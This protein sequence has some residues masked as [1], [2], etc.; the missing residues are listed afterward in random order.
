MPRTIPPRMAKPIDRNF[1]LIIPPIYLGYGVDEMVR[2]EVSFPSLSK[3]R[4][5][6]GSF[7][8]DRNDGPNS[9]SDGNTLHHL[10]AFSV[11]RVVKELGSPR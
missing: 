2:V 1:L 8:R 9:F 7:S 10:F 11:V 3:K 5:P 4:I 6:S